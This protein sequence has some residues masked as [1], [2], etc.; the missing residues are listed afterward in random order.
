MDYNNLKVRIEEQVGWIEYNRPPINAF[1]WEMTRE[2]SGAL[3]QLLNEPHVRVIVFASALEKYFSVGA[4]LQLFKSIGQE[5]MQE[6]VTIL[7]N[8]VRKM[9]RSNKPLLAAIHGTAIG[10]GLEIVLH[11]DVRFASENARFGQPE[12]NIGLIPPVGTTQSLARLLGRPRSI[13]YLYEGTQV[14]AQEAKAMGLVD[15]LVPPEQLHKEAQ[16]YALMLTKKPAEA[17]AVIR[18][19]ITEGGGL[20][21]DEG[22][23]MEYEAVI[24]LAGTADFEEGIRSFFEKREPN[25]S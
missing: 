7:H 3:D 19:T 8:L 9:R 22:L 12:I 21:F 11:C 4:D 25:W 17:L 1:N 23:Q 2:I 24:R 10:A 13:R 20:T 15:F 16:S 6:W 5:G 14:D 18:R